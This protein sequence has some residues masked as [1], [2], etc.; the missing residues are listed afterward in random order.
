[1]GKDAVAYED[2]VRG[3]LVAIR[4]G[5]RPAF[6][7]LIGAVGDE[8][9][10]LSAYHLRQFDPTDVKTLQTTAVVNEAVL[11]LLRNLNRDAGKFP[12][13]KEH[14]MALVSQMMRFTLIDHARKRRVTLESL[15]DPRRGPDG[16]AT[17]ETLADT[18]EDWSESDVDDLLAVD[19]ALNELERL[20]PEYGKRRSTAIE[21]HVFGGLNYREIADELGV[22]DDTARRDCQIALSR[23][24]SILASQPPAPPVT[25]V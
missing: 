13:T 3:L 17:G 7:G 21:L 9:R 22:T 11:R 12:E 4:R 10:R 2:K 1:L 24:Q 16:D 6:D 18:L 20:D 19:Q 15:D 25:G 14:F 23:L 8:M 5:D